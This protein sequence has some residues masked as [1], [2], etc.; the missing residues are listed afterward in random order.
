MTNAKVGNP[1]NISEKL[2]H[3][4]N[5]TLNGLCFLQLFDTTG[6]EMDTEGIITREDS[7]TRL[8][9]NITP[10]RIGYYK[11]LIFGIPKPK[12]KGKWRL[13]LL[14]S[15]LIDCKLTKNP[16][17]D[18]PYNSNGKKDKKKNKMKVPPHR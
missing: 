12:L 3:L 6:K 2:L 9:F 11:L 16:G 10:P 13:P 4:T 5:H 1:L 14:A 18:D 7:D 8:S 17:D 15:F